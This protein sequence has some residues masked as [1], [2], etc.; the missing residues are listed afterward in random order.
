[1]KQDYWL[2]KWKRDETAFHQSGVNPELRAFWSSL[3]LKSSD[4]VFV[5]LCGKSKDMLWLREQGHA[6]IGVELSRIAVSSFFAENEIPVK[7][8]RR[9]HFDVAEADGIRILC[10]NIFD[11]TMEDLEGSTAV[12]DR[13]ALVALP[14]EMRDKY[15][16]H[17]LRILSAG[18]QM[19]LV[20]LEYPQHEMNG[21]PFSVSPANVQHFY[22]ARAEADLLSR[23]SILSDEPRLASRGI[24]SLYS[25]VFRLTIERQ[26]NSNAR[27]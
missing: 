8:S 23:R 15:V 10:G 3:D 5:P 1:M 9:E 14:P 12:Y 2:D 24:T 20:T 16:S 27:L 18:T 25:C 11:V 22:G 13:A 4:G 6:V 19:L 21:P 17:T 26:R 7:W